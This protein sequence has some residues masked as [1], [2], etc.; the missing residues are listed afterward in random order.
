M[1]L[2]RWSRPRRPRRGIHRERPPCVAFLV[3]GHSR[4]RPAG[5]RT[6]GRAEDVGLLDL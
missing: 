6:P 5:N 1:S 4:T 2:E 3:L